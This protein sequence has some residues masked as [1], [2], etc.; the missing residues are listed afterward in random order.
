MPLRVK[1]VAPVWMRHVT[2][3]CV[4]SHIWMRHVAHMNA[5]C[6]TYEC[7]MSHIWTCHVAHMNASCRRYE[8]VMSH[9]WMRHV[10][11]MNVSCRRYEC[12]M[13]HIWMRHV[14][15]MNVSCR[16]YE[17]VMSHIWMC[18]VTH[19]QVKHKLT[20]QV[21][22][23][24]LLFFKVKHRKKNTSS[25]RKRFSYLKSSCHIWI[26]HVTHIGKMQLKYE[27]F[28]SHMNVSCHTHK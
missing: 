4:M 1:S 25:H 26:C 21:L 27:E 6:R 10:A 12:V 16:R 7:V 20:S 23:S 3:E 8:C 2:Y 14:A 11:H 5:S 24:M 22:L 19:T 18:N 9:I 17:C 28:M 15:D 13:S